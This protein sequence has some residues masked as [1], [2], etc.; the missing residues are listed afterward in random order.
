[1]AD[2]KLGNIS[3]HAR[4]LE[5]DSENNDENAALAIITTLQRKHKRLKLIVT[6]LSILCAL[7]ALLL[8]TIVVK[9]YATN[10]CGCVG[11]AA[12]STAN[13]LDAF[14]C[15]LTRTPKSRQDSSS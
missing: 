15:E 14:P 2:N 3:V 8:S 6:C 5:S 10:R 11:D 13:I 1:M 9:Q 4:L 12:P 7:Q